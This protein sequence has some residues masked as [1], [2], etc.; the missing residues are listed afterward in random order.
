MKQ[1]AASQEVEENRLSY[2]GIC[3]KI[4]VRQLPEKKS[5]STPDSSHKVNL[6]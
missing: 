3:S 4:D 6:V 5:S 1:T 2:R